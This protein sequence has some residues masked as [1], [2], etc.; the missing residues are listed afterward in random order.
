MQARPEK[1]VHIEKEAFDRIGNTEIRWLGGA[2]AMINSRGTII[3]IDP[4]LSGFDMPLLIDMPISE[5]EIPYVDGMLIT[6][7]DNDHFCRECQDKFVG[8]VKT[9]HTTNYVA[10]LYKERHDI[11]ANG[12]QIGEGFAINDV[13]VTLTPADH[14]WQNYSAKHHIRDFQKEDYC[15]FYL[16]TEDGAIWAIGDSRLLNIQLLMKEPD[17]ILLDFSDSKWHIGFDNAVTLCNTYP[18]SVIIPWHWGSVD[19]ENMKEF[20]GDPW[21]LQKRIVNPERLMILDPG[22]AY[23]LKK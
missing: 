13:K 12:H 11:E 1:T 6:H 23:I 9:Y 21:E 17:V 5:E 20:N 22:E 7:C 16:E 4:V 18:H 14:D 8:K 10:S 2:G 15:G 19:A 3:M